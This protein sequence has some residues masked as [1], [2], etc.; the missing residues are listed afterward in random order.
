LFSANVGSVIKIDWAGLDIG[1]AT[2][3]ELVAELADYQGLVFK[4]GAWRQATAGEMLRPMTMD[5]G[6]QFGRQ[7]CAPMFLEEMRALPEAYPS[8]QETGFFVGGFNPVVDWTIM[9][10]ALAA[11]SLWRERAVTPLARLMH[12]GLK[13][14]SRPP[15]GTLLKLEARGLRRGREERLEL[16]LAHPDGYFFTAVPVVACLLQYLDGAI[17]RPGLWFQAQVVEPERLLA[18]MQRMGIAIE[19]RP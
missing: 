16:T 9:P 3:E 4:G 15:Y 5:F 19:Q 1:A 18:D 6:D 13:R 12:W 8:L 7:Y 11:A 2:I 14:F 10:L 17:Q